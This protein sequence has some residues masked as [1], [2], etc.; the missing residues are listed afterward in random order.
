MLLAEIFDWSHPFN[1]ARA[2]RAAF[3]ITLQIT[4]LFLIW[5]YY[6][7][8]GGWDPK[9]VD[10]EHTSQIFPKVLGMCSVFYQ[11]L[12]ESCRNSGLYAL[13]WWQHGPC[14]VRVVALAIPLMA[15][16][17]TLCTIYVEGLTI[18]NQDKVPDVLMNMTAFAFVNEIDNW[19]AV[20]IGS[21]TWKP[22][23]K[24][25]SSMMFHIISTLKHAAFFMYA[26]FML[27]Y[28]IPV[29]TIKGLEMY[30][31]LDFVDLV[32]QV[33]LEH[34]RPLWRELFGTSGF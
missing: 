12:D 29:H 15:S 28:Y 11:A 9:T 26:L 13:V 19:V 4:C 27:F 10:C 20:G 25:H 24:S 22:V 6:H 1:W 5:H 32:L 21:Y 3:G 14:L 18:I 23:L 33:V 2:K 8:E 34:V 17:V 16:A 30:T 31:G 7:M